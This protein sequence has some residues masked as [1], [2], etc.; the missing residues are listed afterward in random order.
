MSH[1]ITRNVV[2]DDLDRAWVDERLVNDLIRCLFR[3][4]LDLKRVSNLKVLVALRTNIFQ[5]L[6]FGRRS[7][8]QEEKLRALVLNMRWTRPSLVE[9]LETRVQVAGSSFGLEHATL[10]DLFPNTN[11]T[12]GN[13][14]EYMLD[15]TLLR[16][17]DAIAFVNECFA[18]GIGKTRLAWTDIQTAERSYSA[19]RLMALRDEWKETYPGIAQ[20]AEVFKSAPYRMNRHHFSKR[21]DDV[22]LL[23][24]DPAFPGVR[25]LGDRSAPM[26]NS[27]ND[28]PWE[29]I[30]GPLAQL[31]FDIGLIG[32]ASRASGAPTYFTDDPLYLENGT[33]LS[34]A[35]L[36]YIHRAYQ[37]ALSTGPEFDDADP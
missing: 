22:M 20:V 25:W 12:R 1:S 2:I 28:T 27:G 13:A 8:G 6:D 4:V 11:N 5:E 33:G 17:R 14:I 30:Y 15:R 35:Q 10:A 34:E 19:S 3:A 7:G 23:M 24:S 16:P 21:L 29:E 26:W 31:L 18:L 37:L 9:L 36:F 32:C